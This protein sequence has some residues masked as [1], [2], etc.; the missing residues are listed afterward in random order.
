[1]STEDRGTVS[2]WLLIDAAVA[3]LRDLI[4]E[5]A[6]KQVADLW[7]D[8]LHVLETLLHDPTLSA[9]NQSKQGESLPDSPNRPGQPC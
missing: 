3:R 5:M 6:K 7:P 8:A 1:M 2:E 4:K 9:A